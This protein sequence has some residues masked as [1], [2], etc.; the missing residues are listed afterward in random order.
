MWSSVSILDGYTW[1]LFRKW[2]YALPASAPRTDPR[3]SGGEWKELEI[4]E[5]IT[6]RAACFSEN[7][8]L[9]FVWASGIGVH[10]GYLYGMDGKDATLIGKV[11]YEKVRFC[12]DFSPHDH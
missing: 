5:G 4:G 9:L 10:R 11:S 8:N 2:R 1:L 7:G 6:I 3:F 12:S